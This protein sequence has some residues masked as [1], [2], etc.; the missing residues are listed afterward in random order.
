MN[1]DGRNNTMLDLNYLVNR[2]FRGGPDPICL[3]EGDLDGN[4][5]SSQILDLNLMVNKI[6]R[7]GPNPAQCL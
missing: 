7:G 4:G 3:E 2:I 5:A 6:F 1:Y